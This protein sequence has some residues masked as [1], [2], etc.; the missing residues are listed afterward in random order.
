MRVH[1]KN[2]EARFA[3]S[4]WVHI[5]ATVEIPGYHRDGRSVSGERET[6]FLE[7]NKIRFL[8]SSKVN[9]VPNLLPGAYDHRPIWAI[10]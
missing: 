8:L 5:P 3:E 7:L 1:I 6:S 2:A 4:T 10:K 9:F